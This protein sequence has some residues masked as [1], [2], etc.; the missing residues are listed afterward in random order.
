MRTTIEIPD[1]LYR[2]ALSIA[3]DTSRSLGETVTELMCR[4]LGQNGGAG[5]ISRSA[6]TGLPVVHLGTVIT[7]GEVR[8]LAD[9]DLGRMST[10]HTV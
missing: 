2:Q 4:G 6:R 8:A 7:T 3:E 1:D 5:G 9:D 10:G